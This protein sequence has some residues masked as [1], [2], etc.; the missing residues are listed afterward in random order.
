MLSNSYMLLLL[1]AVN[2]GVTV[3]FGNK[4]LQHLAR[5]EFGETYGA[6][7]NHV[8]HRLGPTH[9]GSK[10]CNEV[11]LDFGGVGMRTCINVSDKRHTPVCGTL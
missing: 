9:R 4:P 2:S 5:A 8:L 1:T 7:G 11:S 10:L 6:V 3:D